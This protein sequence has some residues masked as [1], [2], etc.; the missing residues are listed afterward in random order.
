M[1]C[2]NPTLK[3]C[4]DDTHT[5]ETGTWESFGIPKFL[6]FDC[7]GQNTLLWNVIYIVGKVSKCKCRKCLTWDIQT[8]E[9][10]VMHKRRTESQIDSLTPDH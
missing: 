5:P 4:E 1:M 6:E 9:A 8:F 7:R 2:R 10:Q 3:E